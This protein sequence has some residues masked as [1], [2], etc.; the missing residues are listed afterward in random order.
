MASDVGPAILGAG[1][2]WGNGKRDANGGRMN[3]ASP[4]GSS[5]RVLI[6]D[7]DPTAGSE[8]RKQVEKLGQVVVGQISA[9]E[10]AAKLYREQKPDVVLMDFDLE[11]SEGPNGIELGSQ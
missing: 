9:T 3:L 4:A 1:P 5:R 10:D 8:L 2:R 7:D 11:K 6:V